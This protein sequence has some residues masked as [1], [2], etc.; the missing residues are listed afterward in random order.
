MTKPE[1]MPDFYR[2]LSEEKLKGRIL[3]H[4]REMGKDLVI[5]A[6]HYQRQEIV[7][8]ADFRGDS[9][10]LSRIAS[11]QKARYIL[12]CGVHFMAE[13]AAML[14]RPDQAVFIPDTRAGC[15]LADLAEI[16]DV[17]R[18]WQD[19]AEITGSEK[20]IPIT[21]INSDGELKA[22]CGNHDGAI[23]TSSN[24][25]KVM[26][27]AFKRG[28]K[29][30]FFPDENLG[31]NSGARLGIK[32]A[33]VWDPGLAHGGATDEMIK[34]SK[35]I[36]WRGYCHVHTFFKREHVEKRKAE[37]PGA[38]LVVHP[39]CES[40][41][42]DASDAAGSTEGII[43]Y[44]REAQAGSTIIVGTEIHMVERLGREYEGEKM[45][46]PL[47]RSV[48]PNMQKINLRNLLWV[49]DSLEQGENSWGH[50]VVVP[51][52]IKD[53][54]LIALRRMLEMS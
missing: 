36:L 25:T 53:P 48:C 45:V 23:C 18:A 13:S 41:I 30:L 47:E 5:L 40:E 43:N 4:K 14:A 22:F 15:P 50:Q 29:V 33:L 2:G 38:L 32:D 1:I 37:F 8:V 27:W 17:N 44:I 20:V 39:E 6:H 3:A 19:I 51:P 26:N 35:L 9:L 52:Q 31:R 7:D 24:A 21:Y 54:A 49:L 28:E 46:V 12:F 42:V 34:K 16:D 11:E 10:K